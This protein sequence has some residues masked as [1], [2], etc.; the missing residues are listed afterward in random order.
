MTER[1]PRRPPRKITEAYLERAALLYLQRYTAP[2]EH[3]RRVLLRRVRKSVAYHGGEV[4]EHAEALD[5]VV[6]R[7]TRAGLLDDARWT[8]ARVGE[9]HRRG[10]SL[11]AIRSKLYAKGAPREL[12][13][14]ALAAL[15]GDPD[16]EAAR[17]YAR[18]RRLGPWC[19]DPVERRERRQRHLASL[20]RQGFSYGVAL[21]VLDS[22]PD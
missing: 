1:R 19:L 14:E 6:D 20:A 11:R 2:S 12:V 8:H 18:R 9:L 4:A 7:L 21:K 17:S 13:E 5:H 3:L 16:L 15:E 22:A 10:N